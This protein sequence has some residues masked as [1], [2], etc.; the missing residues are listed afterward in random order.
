MPQEEY[1]DI[2]SI[3]R[4]RLPRLFD[5]PIIP[6]LEDVVDRIANSIECVKKLRFESKPDGPSIEVELFENC[7][8]ESQT[9]DDPVVR[10]KKGVVQADR[11]SKPRKVHKGRHR[12]NQATLRN[13][14]FQYE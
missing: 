2:V 10:F 5:P 4:P 6:I 3:R 1:A 14:I 7:L 12:R 9:G 11:I 13:G 8:T